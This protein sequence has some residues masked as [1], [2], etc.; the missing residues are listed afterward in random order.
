MQLGGVISQDY[1]PLAFYSCKL[2]QA[3][4]NYSTIEQELFSIVEIL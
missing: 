3:Q 2:N 1:K 4:L